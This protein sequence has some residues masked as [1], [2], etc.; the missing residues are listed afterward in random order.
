MLCFKPS[1]GSTLQHFP[2]SSLCT[3]AALSGNNSILSEHGVLCSSK[4]MFGGHTA[5][6][7]NSYVQ[8]WALSNGG[9]D[10]VSGSV[11]GSAETGIVWLLGQRGR[12]LECRAS[13]AQAL[14]VRAWSSLLTTAV[15]SAAQSLKIS[16]LQR[17]GL[18]GS[19]WS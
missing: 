4:Q 10:D 13:A 14:E 9:G 11:K 8:P 6:P 16:L 3:G 18:P 19:C 2:Q 17:T 12:C 15:T 5:I 1:L 7:H